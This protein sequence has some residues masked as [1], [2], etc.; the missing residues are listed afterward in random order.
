MTLFNACVASIS[1][2]IFW[3]FLI[4]AATKKKQWWSNNVRA[5][6]WIDRILTSDSYFPLASTNIMINPAAVRNNVEIMQNWWTCRRW[7]PTIQHLHTPH[8]SL[9][10]VVLFV[11]NQN[12]DTLD[13]NISIKSQSTSFHWINLPLYLARMVNYESKYTILHTSW[14][15]RNNVMS[16]L[17]VFRI[18]NVTLLTIKKWLLHRADKKTCYAA[19]CCTEHI[20]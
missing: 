12:Y 16:S 18:K 8:Y 10:C 5:I 13:Y 15:T 11:E 7:R 17:T 14:S 9:N 3:L 20:S 6:A 1:L 2:Y 19:F 4:V